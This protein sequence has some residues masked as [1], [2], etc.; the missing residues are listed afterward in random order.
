MSSICILYA[1]LVLYYLAGA[2]YGRVGYTPFVIY[3]HIGA[4]ML[5]LDDWISELFP[6]LVLAAWIWVS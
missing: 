2:L 3:F 5:M 4:F 6:L 1:L